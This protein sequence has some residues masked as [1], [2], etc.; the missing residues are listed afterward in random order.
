M[1]NRP[2]PIFPDGAQDI[3]PR[4][5]GRSEEQSHARLKDD[6]CRAPILQIPHESSFRSHD[7]LVTQKL[8][9]VL[10][11]ILL[12]PLTFSNSGPPAACLVTNPALLNEFRI[13]VCNDDC[14]AHWLTCATGVA[15]AHPPT[16]DCVLVPRI[17]EYA[18]GSVAKETSPPP[19]LIIVAASLIGDLSR[20]C[21]GQRYELLG[22]VDLVHLDETSH[23]AHVGGAA[24]QAHKLGVPVPFVNHFGHEF[25][26]TTRLNLN[27]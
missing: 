11:P 24:R 6:D 9:A 16:P 14:T 12:L 7:V 22:N 23:K 21:L 8:T 13:A 20:V 15:I 19:F 10:V 27:L 18:L 5:H 25:C 26:P 4:A 2:P 3:L 17:G 1:G